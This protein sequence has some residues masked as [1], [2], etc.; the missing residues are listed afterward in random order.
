MDPAVPLLD[1]PD[2]MAIVSF[3]NKMGQP[4]R[5]CILVRLEMCVQCKQ[6]GR[7]VS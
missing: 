6:F 3:E 2:N 5:S 4:D 7:R 1:Q